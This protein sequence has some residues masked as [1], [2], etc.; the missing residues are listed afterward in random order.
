MKRHVPAPPPPLP[1]AFRRGDGRLLV[2]G[3]PD[4]WTEEAI[5]LAE[6]YGIVWHGETLPELHEQGPRPGSPAL[7][8]SA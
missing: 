5:L 6:W 1:Y 2:V 8:V 4:L 7:R 3:E